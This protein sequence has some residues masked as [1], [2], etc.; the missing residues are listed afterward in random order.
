MVCH[1]LNSVTCVGASLVFIGA[2]QVKNLGHR[3]IKHWSLGAQ[4]VRRGQRNWKPGI[5]SA[6]CVLV[7][8]MVRPTNAGVQ[9]SQESY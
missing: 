4:L 5:L 3:V 6:L 8:A 1:I 2:L 7:I 9:R